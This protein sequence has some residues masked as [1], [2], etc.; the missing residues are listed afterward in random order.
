MKYILGIDIG[1]QST[2]IALVDFEIKIKGEPV[3]LVQTLYAHSNGEFEHDPNEWWANVCRGIKE[4]F[5]LN[6]IHA[7]D[8]IYI[9]ICGIMHSVAL[10]DKKGELVLDRVQLYSDKRCSKKVA[11]F[12]KCEA[13]NYAYGL[14]ANAPASTWV[15]FKLQWLKQNNPSAYSKVRTILPAK[16]YVNYRMTG[17]IAIDYTEASGTYLM[18]WR[19]ENWSEELAHILDID[20]SI[21]PEIM[22][23]FKPLGV[24]SDKASMETGLLS[25]TPVVVGTSDMAAC[26]LV[27]GMTSKNTFS[28]ETGTSSGIITFQDNPL[29]NPKIQNL[30]YVLPGWT[31]FTVFDLAG[32]AL[33]W[34]RDEFCIEESTRAKNTMCS[35]YSLMDD[36]AAETPAGAEKLIF[37]PNMLGER[38][39]LGSVNA[40]GV[41]FG[42]TL[43]HGKAECIRAIMEGVAFEERKTVDVFRRS[44]LEPTEIW[45]NGGGTKS[46]LWNQIRADIYECPFK[47]SKGVA[48]PGI[49]GSALIAAKAA[50]VIDDVCATATEIHSCEKKFEPSPENYSMYRQLFRLYN[51]MHESLSENFDRLSEI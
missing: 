14:T 50:G 5:I 21:L 51:N 38:E 24:V 31:P 27:T 17:K 4:L 16:D 33:R 44:G 46:D 8:I 45:G 35:V 37:F 26:L 15:A 1:T 49:I 34:F 28:A 42:L 47:I 9:G 40:K 19:K 29:L 32:G 3:N 2:K 13:S 6:S 36:M 30:R 18:D 41:F 12:E 48:E 43:K 23:S 39:N 11:E 20:I 25:G 22:D 7:R 10:L